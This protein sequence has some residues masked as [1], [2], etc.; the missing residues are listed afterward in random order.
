LSV[1]LAGNSLTSAQGLKA[2]RGFAETGTAIRADRSARILTPSRRP[3]FLNCNSRSGSPSR[4][5]IKHSERKVD[6]ST[7]SLRSLLRDDIA[8]AVQLSIP[9]RMR[10]TLQPL[11]R[12]MA[13][14]RALDDGN[15]NDREKNDLNTNEEIRAQ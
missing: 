6:L 2:G 13:L 11:L 14:D 9:A 8:V 7:R 10:K 1:I 4:R 12:V 15:D 3:L 5:K